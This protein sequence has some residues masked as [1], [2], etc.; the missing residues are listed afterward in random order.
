MRT[1]LDR[2]EPSQEQVERSARQQRAHSLAKAAL[3][4]LA[5]KVVGSSVGQRWQAAAL[6]GWPCH[7]LLRQPPCPGA[8]L[9]V[10]RHDLNPQWL[11]AWWCDPDSGR[12][13][14]AAAQRLGT[15]PWYLL[16]RGG[17]SPLRQ[18]TPA[19]HATLQALPGAQGGV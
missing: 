17:T 9:R 8:T 3:R 13:L 19:E 10:V 5:R 14:L 2:L 1:D 15:G 7:L 12:L 18:A 11:R 4:Q 16:A 6:Q